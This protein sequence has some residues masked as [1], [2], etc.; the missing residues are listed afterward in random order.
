MASDRRS[1]V[2]EPTAPER[3]K[4]LRREADPND[5]LIRVE[6][7]KPLLAWQ[8]FDRREAVVAVPTQVVEIVRPGRSLAREGELPGVGTRRAAVH[9][10][11]RNGN[12]S[13][14]DVRRV[15][16]SRPPAGLPRNRLIWTNDNLVA[17]RTLLD[18]KDADSSY[19]Y[20]G[21]V[22]L[23]YIDPPYMVQSDFL[24]ENSIDIELDED[25]HV[26]AKKEPSLVEILA[27]KDTWRQG[28]DSFLSML[29]ERLVLLREL[30][31]PTGSIFVHLDW[32]VM[33]YAK[34]LM[35]EIFGYDCFRTEVVWR[36]RRWPAK[37]KNLQ[38]MHD[39]ILY[40][41]RVPNQDPKFNILY[42]D[43]A[44]ST[45]KTFGTKKQVA[46]FSSGHRKPSQVEEET[47][48]SPLSDVWEIS[49]IAPIGHERVG[50]PT[51]KPL[52]LV[53]RIIQIATNPGDL[54]LDCF[55]GSG[56]TSEAAERLGRAWIGV[57]NSKYAIHLARKRL[58]K[59]HEQPKVTVPIFENEECSKCGNVERKE[60]KVKT[61]ERYNVRPFTI[62]NMG[63]YQRAEEWQ[64]F[65]TH[66]SR[67]RD[68]MIQV[69]GGEVVNHSPLLHGR[70]AK[71]WI[72]VGPLDGPVSANQVWSIAREAERT[73]SR[74]VTI[75]SADYN[76]LSASENEE[77][78]RVTGVSVT[79]R[80]IPASAIDEVRRRL[81]IQRRGEG[82][83]S[84]AI[85]AFYAPLSIIL[86]K[87]VSGR[88]V[89][90]TLDRCDVDIESFIASQRP[91]LKPVTGGMSAAA[92]KKVKAEVEKWRARQDALEEWLSK[93]TSWQK[94]IDFWAI[95]WD[96]GRRI[97][98]D[99][100]PI[101]ETDWQ[102]FRTRRSKGQVDPIVWTAEFEYEKPGQHRVAARVTDVF[103]N[104]GIATVNVKVGS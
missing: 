11:G 100:K 62:E 17:L 38:R 52:A 45:K 90:V 39:T 47:P 3:A 33:H 79:I 74:G 20:R 91:A 82:R 67:Y 53:E 24:A 23:V 32:H 59:M 72:H 68:E 73:E 16:S 104:D 88:L 5:I 69:F 51:Q 46:D 80:I 48:G 9:T 50:F 36:Y 21:K 54:V 35:D 34:V 10:N 19:R 8:G 58:I 64:D 61:S 31:A 22:D 98:E 29:R 83:E 96:Y 49:V 15:S 99:G 41:R 102:S 42:E 63:A 97:G 65:Q 60:R 18:E 103:G 94:F 25:A 40:Y 76:A 71:Y 86:R 55:M 14:G 75:L 70:K 84:M 89:K 56:T 92:A 28:L 44:E 4:T 2:K 7:T 57:D 26:E 87:Q 13:N 95:D 101:F 81:E 1:E 66:G 77:I 78:K 6:P 30:L 85:P 93:A 27:Y 43:L 12:G 37:T